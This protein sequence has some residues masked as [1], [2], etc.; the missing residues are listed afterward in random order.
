MG[1]ALIPPVVV[2]LGKRLVDMIV[3]GAAGRLTFADLW[4]TVLTLGILA[5]I[6]RALQQIQGG[7]QELFSTR[8]SAYA[9]KRFLEKA[10][11]V[12]LGHFDNTDWHDRMQRAKRDMGWRPYQ[13]S[14]TTI[15]LASS[16]ITVIG[17][18]GLLASLHPALVVLSLV[19]LVP[20][21]TMQRRVTRRLYEWWHAHTV[22][23]REVEYL[24]QI[25]A[26][27]STAKELRSFGLSHYFLRR[28]VSLH[29]DRYTSLARF[30]RRWN[31]AALAS[32]IIGGA[33]L[34]GAYGLVASRGLVG[35]LTAGDLAAVIGAFA[36]V[37]Q[38]A[39]LISSSLL[40]LE[41]HATFLDDYFSFLAI[42]RILPTS[43]SP[44]T[45]PSDLAGGLA[46]E[47]VRFTYPGGTHAPGATAARGRCQKT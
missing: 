44:V 1:A 5:G 36:A 47:N 23:E 34:V 10:A 17:M 14:Y 20:I 43:P 46:L 13:L 29:D 30:Y 42:H 39:S 9:R 22:E 24:S 45:L 33:A 19:S 8:V 40:S 21:V 41:Q 27:I 6:T 4:P 38:Q 16:S 12:D 18:L 15:G 28:F 35:T 26:D 7:E 31:W 37:T 3:E 32:G 25:L 2:W 11:D